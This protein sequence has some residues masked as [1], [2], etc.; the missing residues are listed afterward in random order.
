MLII[1]NYVAMIIVLVDPRMGVKKNNC[2]FTLFFHLGLVEEMDRRWFDAFAWF[3]R[4]YCVYYCL[5]ARKLVFID[6]I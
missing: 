6:R 2:T 1:L 5:D 4:S 3:S